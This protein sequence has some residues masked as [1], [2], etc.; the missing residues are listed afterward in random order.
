MNLFNLKLYLYNILDKGRSL[1]LELEN[2]GQDLK[3]NTLLKK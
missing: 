2:P 1:V 3:Q